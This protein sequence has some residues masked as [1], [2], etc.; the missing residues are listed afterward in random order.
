[1]TTTM[2]V[3]A[4]SVADGYRLNLLGDAAVFHDGVPVSLLRRERLLVSLLAL[5]GSRP[6]GYIAGTLWPETAEERARASL[7]QSLRNLRQVLPEGLVVGQ[8]SLGL[9][10]ELAVDVWE[11]RHH[12]DEVLGGATRLTVRRALDA[13]HAITGPELLLGEFDEW[14]DV[15]RRRLQRQRLHALER[16]ARVLKHLGETGWAITAAEA[17]SDLDPLR[18]EP[19]ALL[20]ALYLAEGSI[21]EA[22]RTFDTFR[23]RLRTELRVDPSP[24]VAALL[25]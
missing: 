6:R 5:Q 3:V 21:V 23:R 9:A 4:S 8:T 13:L 18:E 24:K 12:C 17:A 7:R 20:I 11:L 2:P 10:P 14:V 16:L 22:R 25:R 15:E 19:T 1:M